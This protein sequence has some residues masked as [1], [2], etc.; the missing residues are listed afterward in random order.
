MIGVI[1]YI[2]N[3]ISFLFEGFPSS[4]LYMLG[5]EQWNHTDSELVK[6]LNS[7]AKVELNVDEERDARWHLAL[8][9]VDKI[10]NYN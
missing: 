7:L 10:K 4:L 3:N 9:A 1:Q 2:V 5:Y 6:C 8:D